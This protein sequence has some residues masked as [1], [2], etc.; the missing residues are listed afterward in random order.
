MS[1]FRGILKA[2]ALF[3]SIQFYSVIMQLVRTKFLAVLLG[4]SGMGIISLISSTITLISS[5]TDFGVKNAC[6]REI[7]K[8]EAKENL[9]KA[10]KLVAFLTGIVGSIITALFSK[11]LSQYLFSSDDYST[12]FL[13]LST[14]VFL[15]HS[16]NVNLAILQALQRRKIFAKVNLIVGLLST[17][18]SLF[19][20]Y[21]FGLH[22]V[23]GALLSTSLITY[24]Y[25]M[26]HTYQGRVRRE[27]IS[28]LWVNARPL[29]LLGL[30]ISIAGIASNVSNY[31]IRLLVSKVFSEEQLGFYTSSSSMI[32]A[33][34]GLILAAMAMDFFPR[35]SQVSNQQELSEII[36]NQ[37]LIALSI[38][39]PLL[40]GLISFM[41]EAVTALY[42]SDFLPMTH[43]TRLFAVG[44]VLKVVGWALGYVI[45]TKGS[46]KIFLLNEIAGGIYQV[47]LAYIFTRS[48]SFNGLGYALIVANTLYALQTMLIVRYKLIVKLTKR[49]IGIVLILFAFVSAWHYS[50]SFANIPLSIHFL[51]IMF[52]TLLSSL[53]I[54]N[55]SK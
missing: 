45:L 43:L 21:H 16:S 7:A 49:L 14:V 31:S 27:E 47:G 20:Y 9:I 36:R 54:Y 34:L 48:G 6:V 8:A 50:V 44:A 32:N 10:S 41:D 17:L 15:T 39:S 13:M 55:K 23:I 28:M 3:G 38:I 40:V 24:T 1:E 22:G 53:F 51:V 42:S 26:Y 52:T 29:V 35:I 4:P 12:V 11:Q 5:F 33:Y 2:T 19:F 37:V 30:S 46:G 25:S 18:I